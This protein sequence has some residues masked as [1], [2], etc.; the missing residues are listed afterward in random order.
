MK[1][2]DATPDHKRLRLSER[3]FALQPDPR[4]VAHLARADLA[5]RPCHRKQ[6]VTGEAL[7]AA[8]NDE[9]EAHAESDRGNQFWQALSKREEIIHCAE[10]DERPCQDAEAW[11]S[12]SAACQPCKRL[13]FRHAAICAGE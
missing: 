13:R 7:G 3:M 9:H 11:S 10:R 5:L 1:P 4:P 6:I 8:N 2:R 12:A